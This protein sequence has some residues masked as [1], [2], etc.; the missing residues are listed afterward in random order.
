MVGRAALRLLQ[1]PVK[2]GER[3][4]CDRALVH[5]ASS[6]LDGLSPVSR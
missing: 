5:G 6:F 3:G 1:V 2:G 4:L